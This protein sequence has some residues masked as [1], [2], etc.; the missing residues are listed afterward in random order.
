MQG[1]VRRRAATCTEA[2]RHA[3]EERFSVIASDTAAYAT[4]AAHAEQ[5]HAVDILAF[6]EV[7]DMLLPYFET[8]YRLAP[9]PG[10]EQ[11]YALLCEELHRC[12]KIGIAQ[13]M[14]QAQMQLAILAPQGQSLM[15][16][17]LR[18]TGDAKEPSLTDEDLIHAAGMAMSMPRSGCH[19]NEE[20]RREAF[21][22]GIPALAEY[23]STARKAEGF[24]LADREDLQDDDEFI[25]ESYL[26]SMRRARHPADGYAMRAKRTRSRRITPIQ[27]RR[28]RC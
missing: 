5:I 24:L 18:W 12:R 14:I 4:Y 25:D 23:E 27:R 2:R 7:R 28:L 19:M 13:V 1:P 22:S 21:R 16:T 6:V 10:G 3:I 20:V 15:L 17:T 8:S 9:V 11:F 26:V